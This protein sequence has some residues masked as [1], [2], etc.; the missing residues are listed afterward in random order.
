MI[1]LEDKRLFAYLFICKHIKEFY[2]AKCNLIMILGLCFFDN[3]VLPLKS[4][5]SEVELKLSVKD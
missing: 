3:S 4:K 2:Q 5:E 1:K